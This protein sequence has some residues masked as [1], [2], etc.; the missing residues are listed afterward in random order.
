MDNTIPSSYRVMHE[1]DTYTAFEVTPEIVQII[2]QANN[3]LSA[4]QI[5]EGIN[6][7]T[8]RLATNSSVSE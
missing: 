7:F 1:N 2:D 6:D 4:D 5:L 3:H 8:Q